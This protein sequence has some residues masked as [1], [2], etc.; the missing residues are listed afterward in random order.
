M[1]IS[2]VWGAEESNP[3]VGTPGGGS[4]AQWFESMLDPMQN[5]VFEVYDND[6]SDAIEYIRQHRQEIDEATIKSEVASAHV[7][8]DGYGTAIG[9]SNH[10]M[11]MKETGI[12]VRWGRLYGN[13][14]MAGLWKASSLNS[15][16]LLMNANT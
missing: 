6:Y 2:S 5:Y 12:I 16:N 3:V 7:V 15:G 10:L 1:T 11:S 4:I 13:C 14:L 8:T 9:V